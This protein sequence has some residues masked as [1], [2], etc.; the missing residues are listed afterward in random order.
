MVI[1]RKTL[2]SNLDFHEDLEKN[3]Y[4]HGNLENDLYF[5][6]NLENDLYFY[7]K[8]EISVL[9]RFYSLLNSTKSIDKCSCFMY[10]SPLNP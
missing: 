5:Y 6:G 8:R 1:L 10:N 9:V 3:L 7:G 4:F 2:I